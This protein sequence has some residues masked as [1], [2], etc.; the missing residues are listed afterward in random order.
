MFYYNILFI[1]FV[2]SV[3][4]ARILKDTIGFPESEEN[5][6]LVNRENRHPIYLPS[7]CGENELYYPGDQKDDWICDCRPGYLYYPEKNSCWPAFR[8]GPCSSDEHLVLRLNSVIPICVTNPCVDGFVMWKGRCER[9]GSTGPCPNEFPPAVLWIN[10]TTITVECIALNFD[11]R[12]D[13][14]T[15]IEM[16]LPGCKRHVQS[17]CVPRIM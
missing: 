7:L 4:S 10:A 16:C 6:N 15:S 5:V 14:Y 3:K 12:Y 11:N 13:T 9:L 2:L 1:I 17:M 8:R